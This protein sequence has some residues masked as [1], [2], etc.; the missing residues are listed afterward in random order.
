MN[1]KRN[2]QDCCAM[3]IMLHLILTGMALLHWSMT[4]V[5]WP[6]SRLHENPSNTTQTGYAKLCR[7]IKMLLKES[8]GRPVVTSQKTR[9]IILHIQ[10][11]WA[12]LTLIVVMNL[13]KN[14]VVYCLKCSQSQYLRV[15]QRNLLR[16]LGCKK[17]LFKLTPAMKQKR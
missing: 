16:L 4:T 7:G 13:L 2:V 11:T 1:L 6:V 10:N 17:V 5:M 15:L 3:L 9:K 12:G 8:I 14:G